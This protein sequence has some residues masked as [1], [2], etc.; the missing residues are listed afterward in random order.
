MQ[1]DFKRQQEW[2]SKRKEVI[3]RRP[4]EVERKK[5]CYLNDACLRCFMTCFEM[6]VRAIF[7]VVKFIAFTKELERT[8]IIIKIYIRECFA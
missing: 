1:N 2:M 7:G 5:A 3:R 8:C 4:D 6:P